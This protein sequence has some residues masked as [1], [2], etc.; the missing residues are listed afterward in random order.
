MARNVIK[1]ARQVEKPKTASEVDMKA[2]LN[3]GLF[4]GKPLIRSEP[5]TVEEFEKK[6][7]ATKFYDS[8]SLIDF[9]NKNREHF[10]QI[11][12]FYNLLGKLISREKSGS[13]QQNFVNQIK[14]LSNDLAKLVQKIPV[15]PQL[16]MQTLSYLLQLHQGHNIDGSIPTALLSLF[17]EF[18]S[19]ECLDTINTVT[20]IKMAGIVNRHKLLKL[21]QEQRQQNMLLIESILRKRAGDL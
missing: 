9:Y 21:S 16:F 3:S 14:L 4:E 11:Q 1:N 12:Y 13:Q 6:F 10:T 20:L 15:E 18:M 5:K 19:D 2:A 17:K 8:D 7:Q